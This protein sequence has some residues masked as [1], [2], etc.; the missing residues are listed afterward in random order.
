LAGFRQQWGAGLC[1][2]ALLQEVFKNLLGI[3]ACSR[4]STTDWAIFNRALS[5]ILD[6]VSILFTRIARS[7]AGS[8]HSRLR[9]SFTVI[10]VPASHDG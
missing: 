10:P 8:N 5:P 2:N 6:N 9:R 4:M 3:L 7:G 1:S